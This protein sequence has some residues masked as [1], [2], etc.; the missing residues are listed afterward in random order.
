[1]LIYTNGLCTQA[2]CVNR[3]LLPFPR[4]YNPLGKLDMLYNPNDTITGP[5]ISR[6]IYPVP[7]SDNPGS[8]GGH[9]AEKTT[10]RFCC[11]KTQAQNPKTPG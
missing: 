7:L 5:N 11:E 4:H 2:F 3:S 10:K 6:N 1:M 8:T 9:L